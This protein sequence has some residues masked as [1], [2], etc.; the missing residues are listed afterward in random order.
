[1]ARAVGDDTIIEPGA[2]VII[3]EVSGVKVIVEAEK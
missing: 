1:M 2:K 3:K